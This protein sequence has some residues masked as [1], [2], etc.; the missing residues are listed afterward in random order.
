MDAPQ[1]SR[2]KAGLVD[3]TGF[4]P[5]LL[6]TVAEMNTPLGHAIRRR[7]QEADSPQG[8]TDV[9]FDSAL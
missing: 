9:V 1:E 4:S 2:R 5:H 8:T 7:L 6:E 3:I